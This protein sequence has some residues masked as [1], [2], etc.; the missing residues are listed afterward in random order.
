MERSDSL[1]KLITVVVFLALAFYIGYSFLANRNDVLRTVTATAVQIRESV[2]TEGW[3][4]RDEATVAT[5]AGSASVTAS[6]GEKV[7]SGGQ[8]A[9]SYSDDSSLRRAEEIR[10]L[11]VQLEKLREIQSAKSGSQSAKDSIYAL[12]ELVHGGS[13]E[14]LDAVLLDIGLYVT[15]G[16]E[17]TADNIDG[18][19]ASTEARLNALMNSRSGTGIVTAPSSGTFSAAVDGY[20]GIKPSDL[21]EKL[22]PD[23]VAE[24]FSHPARLPY[25]T[26]GKIVSGIKWYY[27][28]VMPSSWATRLSGYRTI[29]VEFSRTY[30]NTIPMTVESIGVSEEGSCVVVLSCSKYLQNVAAVRGMTAELIFRSSSGIRVPKEAL[31]LDDDGTTYLYRLSGMQ[32]ERVNVTIEGEETDYYLVSASGTALRAG[33]EIITKASELFDGAVVMD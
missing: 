29:T 14:N 3:A 16:A 33:D 24:M 20:E 32:A 19:I 23:D 31:H 10:D 27:V 12:S 17:I 9:I 25:G 7:A 22:K 11:T 2:A 28:T 4:V 26:F 15:G 6:E 18:T 30:S 1:I 5:A 13:L 21:T 8:L